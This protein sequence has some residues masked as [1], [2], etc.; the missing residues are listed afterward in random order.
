M[1][2]NVL[3][4]KYIFVPSEQFSMLRVKSVNMTHLKNVTKKWTRSI[5]GNCEKEIWKELKWHIGNL[6]N[7]SEAPILHQDHSVYAPSQWE[8][9]LQYKAI[10]HWLGA[11]TEWSLLHLL[12]RYC[13]DDTFTLMDSADTGWV[14]S[15]GHYFQRAQKRQ[16]T[17]HLCGWYIACPVRF[18]MTIFYIC[19]H[20]AVCNAISDW[21]RS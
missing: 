3:K 8:M 19:H 7:L 17:A 13:S 1:W 9:A 2:R 6:A 16:P 4:Y 10:S 5:W 21:T 12:V 11:Y 14:V 18:H 15:W 20:W